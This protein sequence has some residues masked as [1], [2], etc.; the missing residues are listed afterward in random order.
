MRLSRVSG[1]Q[2]VYHESQEDNASITSLRKTM[3]L[4][5]VSGR[6]CVYHESQEDNA[7]ITSLTK[8][9]RVVVPL[10]LSAAMGGS[11]AD[12]PFLGCLSTVD[13]VERR[14]RGWAMNV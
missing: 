1:R 9:I 4:S 5:R 13:G 2:C 6:Q 14:I 3:R 10:V 7:S 12:T 8:T 11:V